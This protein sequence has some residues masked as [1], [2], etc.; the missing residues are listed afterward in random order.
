MNKK[1]LYE[2]CKI[3]VDKNN[4]LQLFNNVQEEDIEQLKKQLDCK[5]EG[6]YNNLKNDIS[7]DILQD[8]NK[9]LEKE[10]EQLKRKSTN[11]ELELEE[12]KEIRDLNI[13]LNKK[14]KKEIKELEEHLEY[15]QNKCE[16][17]E[18][19]LLELENNDDNMH[20]LKVS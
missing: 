10:N 19:E 6:V 7:I 5:I 1:E 15:F 20:E 12:I 18:N 11:L 8:Q 14:L 4:R 3:L 9:K 2:F 17:L 16:H 13:S